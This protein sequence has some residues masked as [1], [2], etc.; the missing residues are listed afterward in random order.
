MSRHFFAE[1]N[2]FE[3]GNLKNC[4][5]SVSVVPEKRTVSLQF[6]PCG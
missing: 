5:D 4:A 2:V 3:F 6:F 1:I